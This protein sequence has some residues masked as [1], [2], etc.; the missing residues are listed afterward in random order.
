MLVRF[1]RNPR[2]ATLIEVRQVMAQFKELLYLNREL[3]WLEFN[4]RVLD[5]ARNTENPLMERLKFLAITASNL[6]E[7]YMVRVGGL[8]M[9]RDRQSTH[10]D[11]SGMTVTQQLDG[12][13]TRTLE[14]VKEQYICL[15]ELEEELQSQGISRLSIEDLN[16]VQ[17]AALEKN[18]RD[19]IVSVLTPMAVDAETE[20]PH[21]KSGTL[22]LCVR[23]ECGDAEE[24]T[25]YAV[26]A[27]SDVLPR[28]LTLPS[29]KGLEFLLLEEAVARL[30]HHFF[31]GQTVLEATP[32][33]IT[34]NADMRV[35]EDSAADLMTGME[36]VL[37][38]R[39]WSDC[40]R[41][42]L[43][44]KAS[45]EIVSFLQEKLG[46]DDQNLIIA[47]GPMDLAD[48]MSLT[49][50]HGYEH[51]K[52]DSWKPQESP[53]LDPAASI[54]ET[55]SKQSVLLYHPYE[56]FEPVVRFI[57][58]AAND[59][60]VLAIKQTLYR[61]SK[62]S[63]IVNALIRAAENGKNVTAL[64][65][66]KARFDEQRNIDW[67]RQM[68]AAGV[69]V[70]H[71]VKGLKT[72]C[73]ICIVVRRES[74]GVQRYVHFGTGNYNES[75]ARLYGDA[76]YLT[77]DEDLGND[78]ISFFNSISGFSQPQNLR[79]IEAAPFGLRDRVLELIEFEI[80]RKEEGQDAFISAKVN[81]LVDP[82]IID[83]LYRASQAGVE[84]QLNIRGICCL[85]PGVAGISERIRVVS[86]ID[87]YLEHA[88]VFHFHHG[89]DDLVFISSADW[90]PRNLDKR[91]ELLVPVEDRQ[92]RDKLIEMLELQ[93]KD[94][95][96]GREL[97]SDGRYARAKA[98]G[99]SKSGLRSQWALQQK[100]VQIS[101]DHQQQKLTE[102]ETHQ[103]HV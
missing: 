97:D 69:H 37:D 80:Q 94:T 85:Q 4:Q 27:L 39:I 92:A 86:I 26:I 67:A 79:K 61:T 45:V 9:L 40:V 83:A 22:H 59:P 102:F 100:A 68:E 10:I 42:E 49:S 18:Y 31:P 77:A 101:Q 63:P 48:F 44:E 20:M 65:E 98:Q 41:L 6:D 103:S 52:A 28:M 38:E 51:L 47:D 82:T 70:I 74:H 55:L 99:D 23:L 58:Q 46:A 36:A 29:E 7:F 88:R 87:R 64:V 95:V 50:L 56:S 33:R 25:L 3:S 2:K 12:I 96:K 53:S 14:M 1:R 13:H 81:S 8:Q 66:L 76:S 57:E 89:G 54:F 17:S 11:I 30:V 5:E 93:M 19:E 91:I 62:K 84:I 71:G 15:S 90:M 34:R 78:A 21:L 75:T 72:H 16:D 35:R 43:S 60:D 32:F 73:K 24:P